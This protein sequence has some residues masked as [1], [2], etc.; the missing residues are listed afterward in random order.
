VKL[1]GPD[2]IVECVILKR[3]TV[4]QDICHGHVAEKL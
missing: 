1:L 2:R 3:M 4:E